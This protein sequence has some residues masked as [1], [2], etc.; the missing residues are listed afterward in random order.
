MPSVTYL[1]EIEA[2]AGAFFE[3]HGDWLVAAHFG[4]P[5][6]E[7]E[8]LRRAAGALDLCFLG[9]LRVT[10]RD[11]IRYLNNMLTNDI[12]RV[13]PG[14]GCYAALLNRQG[15]MESDLWVH[16]FETDV[17]L[18]CPPSAAARVRETLSRHVVS[19]IVSLESMDGILGILS[20]Q[21]PRA[22]EFMEITLDAKLQELSPLGHQTVMRGAGTW[23]VV[24]RDRTGFDGF[25]LWLPL[26]ELQAVWRRW[27]EFEGVRA[28]GLTALNWSRIEAG[29]PWYGIDM[30]EK[31]LPMEMGLDAA[32]SMSKGCYRGQE[33]VARI[34][35]RGHLD[36]RL[37]GISLDSPSP[38]IKGAEVRSLGIKIGEVTSAA[39]SPR[40]GKP[41]ALAV[42]KTAC[43]QPGTPVEVDCDG[44]LRAGTIVA[45]PLQER[46]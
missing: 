29:I 44:Y 42:V 30:D 15:M 8:A 43:L 33:I 25:D 32:I 1:H 12:T 21:G 26:T 36:R 35:H 39:L 9:K 3:P 37:G 16:V 38:P 31:S 34:R 7:Y 40:L 6:T 13:A 28:A 4:D 45:L 2:S 23:I 11:R 19:D 27:A 20:L 17:W 14:V 24:R 22:R 18:E 41:L 46:A 5:R 10:G